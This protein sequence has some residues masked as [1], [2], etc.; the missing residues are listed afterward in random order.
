MK[1]KAKTTL[2]I[3]I[4][5]ELKKEAESII[6]EL[7]LSTSSAIVLFFKALIRQKGLPFDVRLE[8]ERKKEKTVPAFD[9]P[10]PKQTPKRRKS[11]KEKTTLTMMKAIERL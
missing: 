11:A 9:A 3:R 6:D 10:K 4:D 5:S 2:N 7:G 8:K 1:E